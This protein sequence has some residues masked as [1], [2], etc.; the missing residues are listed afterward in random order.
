MTYSEAKTKLLDILRSRFVGGDGGVVILDE[1]TVVKP[2]GW[3]LYY[4]SRKFV[5]SG[6]MLESLVGHGPVIVAS[7]T[8]EVVETGSRLP[9]GVQIK[10]FER[11]RGL[12]SE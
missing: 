4:N 6:D 5:E 2:Y 8:G 1:W 7:A 3:I 10:S 12:P 11:E 9:G